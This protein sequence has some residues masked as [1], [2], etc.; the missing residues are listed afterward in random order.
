M[1]KKKSTVNKAG[2]YTKPGMRKKIFQRI[3]RVMNSKFM[4]VV[5]TLII[6]LII[7]A[8]M[9]NRS[10]NFV[11]PVELPPIPYTCHRVVGNISKT[12]LKNII[13]YPKRFPKTKQK[14]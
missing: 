1:A 12:A 13:S 8:C 9:T 2:N 7:A 6:V 10:E 11:S 5:S 4:V 14:I 3:N